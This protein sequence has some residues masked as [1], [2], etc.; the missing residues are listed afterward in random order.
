MCNRLIQD[1]A[2]VRPGQKA[3]V[4]MR[5][6]GGEFELEFGDAVFAGAAKSESKGYW[7]SREQAE[8]VIIPRISRFGEKHKSTGA[9]SWEDVPA[10][11]ALEGLLLPQ[12]P[13]KAYRLLKVMTQP[14][15]LEQATRW[16]NDRAPIFSPRMTA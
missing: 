11:T 2:E 1:G 9:Q 12:P 8:P 15:T 3:R 5:G 14:A 7:I 4:L 6:P 16:G 10:G 13:G